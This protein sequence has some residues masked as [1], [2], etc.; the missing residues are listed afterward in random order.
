MLVDRTRTLLPRLFV[1]LWFALCASLGFGQ[2]AGSPY[3]LNVG[4]ELAYGGL[5]LGTNL[6]GSVLWANISTDRRAGAVEFED[7]N[8]YELPLA[9]YPAP[10]AGVVSAHTRDAGALAPLL[11]LAFPRTRAE[12]GRIGVLLAETY[13]ISS[14]VTTALKAGV[15][16]TRP[17]V[18]S[19]AMDPNATLTKHDRTSFISGHTSATATGA[20][21]FAQ[22]Y[23]DYHP[24]SPARPFVWAA[25][26]TLPAVSGF[27]RVRAG[28]HYPTDV[29]AGYLVGGAIGIAVPRLHR[30]LRPIEGLD[31]SPGI[32]GFAATYTF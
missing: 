24:D 22:V 12:A 30:V 4:Q 9:F 11:L 10:R 15:K 23:A 26:A 16:R 1:L 14:G 8:A 21:F 28:R 19:E 5:G 7:I 29:I 17:Y 2:R 18:F 6:L 31:V 27:L 3:A 25:A 32:D 13:L 20:F